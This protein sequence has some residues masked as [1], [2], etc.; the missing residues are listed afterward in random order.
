MP[1]YIYIFTFERI[2]FK[3]IHCAF[4]VSDVSFHIKCVTPL[5]GRKKNNKQKVT[6]GELDCKVTL[7][8]EPNL[9]WKDMVIIKDIQKYL[10]TYTHMIYIKE[11]Q[12]SSLRSGTIPWHI[13]TA[14]SIHVSTVSTIWLSDRLF[15]ELQRIAALAVCTLFSQGDP[16]RNQRPACWG[17]LFTKIS[18]Y[19]SNKY[20]W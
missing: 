9:S 18:I 4:H 11:N 1:V 2:Y 8:N 14:T 12:V 5:L 16:L 10:H 7:H 15:P 20:S 13:F 19:V 6:S 3:K 17:W